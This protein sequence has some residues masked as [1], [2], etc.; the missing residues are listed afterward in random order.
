VKRANPGDGVPSEL[1]P[2][3]KRS[4]VDAEQDDVNG[5]PIDLNQ[6]PLDEL[7]EELYLHLDLSS[8]SHLQQASSFFN[9]NI[10]ESKAWYR[11]IMM[12]FNVSLEVMQKFSALLD[13]EEVKVSFH[14]IYKHLHM[15]KKN[16]QE[17]GVENDGEDIH[18]IFSDENLLWV[19]IVCS[20]VNESKLI[21][22]IPKD[23]V[24]H[25]SLASIASHS[26]HVSKQLFSSFNDGRYYVLHLAVDSNNEEFFQYYLSRCDVNE[27][28]LDDI[29]DLEDLEDLLKEL[30]NSSRLSWA[31]AL[32][33]KFDQ[34]SSLGELVNKAVLAEQL[35]DA[36]FFM[37]KIVLISDEAS[38]INL[39]EFVTLAL[40]KGNLKAVQIVYEELADVFPF[41]SEE[42]H[43]YMLY[44]AAESG[45]V[46][47]LQYVIE[48]WTDRLGLE[49]TPEVELTL[50]NI[51][52]ASSNP[53][54][55]QYF[56][57]TFDYDL[58]EPWRSPHL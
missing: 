46:E 11:R 14:E 5:Y 49:V 35:D 48:E 55:R 45:K 10:T 12:D 27:F 13:K 52:R 44:A 20:N 28:S 21:E 58:N 22:V 53:D 8:L 40:K 6:W 33:N 3:S 57:E 24:P 16:W 47:I 9:R 18:W 7:Y 29:D 25:A 56:S 30:C 23:R 26:L 34:L 31:K 36:I 1:E 37:S 41:V 38:Q 19:L 39:T 42:G 54:L 2:A 17:R 4:R 15:L 32:L 50:A 51:I 43:E